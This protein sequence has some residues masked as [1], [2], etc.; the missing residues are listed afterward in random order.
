MT[1]WSKVSWTDAGQVLK[2]IRPKQPVPDD[3]GVAP[4]AYCRLLAERGDLES[5]VHFIGAA[6]PRYEAVVWATQV[7]RTRWAKGR[8]DPILAAILQWID[9]PSETRRR[10][11]HTL[12]QDEDDS[13]AGLLGLAVFYSGGSI[14]Q[15]DLPAILPPPHAC[16][17]LA[18]SAILKAAYSQPDAD[19]VVREAIRLGEA[20][21][22]QRELA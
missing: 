7:L 15:P 13:P 21:A 10:D 9:D 22:T 14:S 1:T 16:G 12:A 2:L 20:V 5:A 3:A 4:D 8:T 18:S 6:L 11:L 17:L 19:A